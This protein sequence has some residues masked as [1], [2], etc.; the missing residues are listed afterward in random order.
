MVTF[1]NLSATPVEER[2]GPFRHRLYPDRP[3]SPVYNTVFFGTIQSAVA[4]C[5]KM[6][7]KV[8]HR[9][10]TVLFRIFDTAVKE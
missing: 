4:S 9:K 5:N 10:T 2:T 7:L 8:L 6:I 3:D 1:R